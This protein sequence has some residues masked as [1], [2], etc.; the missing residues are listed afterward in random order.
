MGMLDGLINSALG[1]MLGHGGQGQHHQTCQ[2]GDPPTGGNPTDDYCSIVRLNSFLRAI[3][4]DKRYGFPAG[5][6]SGGSC[7]ALDRTV[8]AAI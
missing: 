7:P 1:G 3:A 6:H 4:D 8:R 5:R 2:I